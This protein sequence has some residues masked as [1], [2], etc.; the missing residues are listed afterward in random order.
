MTKEAR[1][2][3]MEKIDSSIKCAE[4]TGQLQEK[5]NQTGFSHTI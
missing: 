5:K 1:T 3:N 4:K 2:Y